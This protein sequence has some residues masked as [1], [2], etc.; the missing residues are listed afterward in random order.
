MDAKTA[1]EIAIILS[2]IWVASNW[3]I[4]LDYSIACLDPFE[5]MFIATQEFVRAFVINYSAI[6]GL[7]AYIKRKEPNGQA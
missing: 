5:Q 4:D 7:S 2:L 6:T 1:V 3:F